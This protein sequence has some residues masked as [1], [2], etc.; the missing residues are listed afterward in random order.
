M[1]PNN[2]KDTESFKK[3]DKVNSS[4]VVWSNIHVSNATLKLLCYKTV[5]I[6]YSIKIVKKKQIHHKSLRFS[7]QTITRNLVNY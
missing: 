2:Q 1:S 6:I 5:P 4:L 3:V 7:C